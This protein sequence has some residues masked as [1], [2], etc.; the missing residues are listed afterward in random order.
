MKDTI[1]IVKRQA[2]ECEEILAK[3]MSGKGLIFKIYKKI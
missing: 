3:H 2:I 1:K